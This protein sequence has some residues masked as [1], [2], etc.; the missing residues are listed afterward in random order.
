M[1]TRSKT[2]SLE[3]NLCPFRILALHIPHLSLRR[4]AFTSDWKMG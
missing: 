1:Q 4:P 2:D 3:Q